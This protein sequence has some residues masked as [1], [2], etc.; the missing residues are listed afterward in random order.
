MTERRIA[1][2]DLGKSTAKLVLANATSSG[3]LRI[4]SMESVHHNG[5]AL[6]AFRAWYDR[7]G[8]ATCRALG[9]TG[10]HADEIAEPALTALP[11]DVC[12]EAALRVRTD[13]QGP[14]NLVSVGARGYSVLTRDERGRVQHIENDKCSSGTGETIVKTASR[15]DMDLET[16]DRVAFEAEKI[17]PI[18]ARCSVF[19]KSEMTHFGNQGRPVA[20]LFRGYFDSIA[21]YVAAL[22]SRVRV[23]GPIYLIGGGSRLQTLRQRLAEHVDARVEVPDH[24][25]LFEAMGAACLAAEGGCRGTGTRLPARVEELIV[26]KERSFEVLTPA[27][28]WKDR[29][30]VMDSPVVPEGAESTSAV[31]GIDLGSTGSKAV[32]TSV[33]TGDVVLDLYD[34]TGG[35]PVEATQRLVRAILER[36]GEHGVD[37]RAI[38]L[39]GSGREAAATVLRAALPEAVDRILVINEIVAH[40]TAAI[41]CDPDKGKSLSVVEIGGQDAKFIQIAD[42]RIVES[43]MNK[44]CSAGTGSFLEEQAVFYGVHDI[45]EFT[46][47]ARR[48]TRPPDLGQMCTVFVAEAAAEAQSAGF[49]V[50]DLFAGFQYSVIHNYLHR[51]MG[52]RTFGKRVFFQGKPASGASL[53][54]TLAAVADRDIIVPPNPGAMGA[55]GIGLCAVEEMGREELEE[56]API[57]LDKVLD[58]RVTGR[59]E[60]QCNDKRCATLCTIERTA[61]AVAENESVVY[62]GGACPKYEISTAT[63]PKLDCD[64][65][66]AFDERQELL[67][68]F[69]EPLPVEAADAAAQDAD[70][71]PET[72]VAQRTVGIPLASTLVGF[73][74]WAVTLLRELG[75]PVKVLRPDKGTLSRGEG[76]CY[77]YDACAPVKIAHGVSDGEVDVLFAPKLLDLPDRDGDGGRTCA[78][79]QAMPDMVGHALEARGR[80]VDVVAP[81][82]TLAHGL[83]SAHILMTIG[84]VAKRIGAD[85]AR[86]MD[87]MNRAAAAQ[88]LYEKRLKEIGERTLQYGRSKGLA[89]VVVCG[90]LHVIMEPA[91]NAGIPGILRQNGVLALPQDCYPI[92]KE[93]DALPRAAWLDTKRGLRV[94]LAARERGDVFPLLLSAFACSPASFSEQIFT[95]LM[96]GYP[97]TALETDGHGGTAGYV[98]RIQSFLHG[99]RSYRGGASP[100]SAERLKLI[101]PPENTPIRSDK[102]AQLVMFAA[103]DG[104]GPLAAATYRSMGFDA[105]TA[106]QASP[107]TYALG[108]KDCSGKECLPYQLLWG[109]FRHYLETKPSKKRRVLLQISGQGACRN[110]M[111]SI[112]DKMSLEHLGMGDKV[113]LR[114]FSE[115][116]DVEIDA[117]TR[118]LAGVIV[119]DIVNQLAAYHRPFETRAGEVDELRFLM[120]KKLE[121]QV[122]KVPPDGLRRWIE[123][124][125]GLK[126]LGGLVDEAAEAFAKFDGDANGCRTVMLSGD[127]YVRIDEYG[128][129]QLVRRLNERGL[130]VVLDPLSTSLEYFAGPGAEDLVGGA[131]SVIISSTMTLVLNK[132]RSAL[133]ARA[134]RVHPWLPVPSTSK[135]LQQAEPVLG[136]HPLGEAPLTI[137]SVL[138]AWKERSCDGAVVVGPWGCSPSL[139]TESLLRHQREIPLLFLYL[140]GAP[141]NERKLNGFAHR[142]KT[143]ERRTAS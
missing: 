91:L 94:A 117:V 36:T 139:I 103:S 129:E 31:L 12:L 44:A 114:H 41:R 9:A 19:A 125:N 11:E 5:N 28:E 60:I 99:V 119:W 48:A 126:V 33:A 82:L 118:F 32:L 15:F 20:E 1:G 58:A 45:C 57:E 133:Y 14:I 73:L 79:E 35:N 54:W 25:L 111:F 112:K 134:R 49:E 38:G 10:V 67:R 121:A 2:V 92:P 100:V 130:R 62:S 40:A 61:V 115:E 23:G 105:V 51:V 101:A 87:A 78:M 109:S 4:E 6:S 63:R 116:P 55:W 131:S 93:I 56:D 53:A 24:A 30:T 17:I 108:R 132:V 64:A 141:L 76:R 127:I 52:Q 80:H 7:K 39:T 3:A 84:S 21:R 71:G 128:N 89:V 50:A 98:T 143:S 124:G 65:P 66:S 95:T 137:G 26:P 106:T 96:H 34:R 104:I 18:T 81:V 85:P 42:G 135:P 16:A 123:V 102:D 68:E 142:L 59:S 122:E 110:C 13:L 70:G 22:L 43:D 8:A 90:S 120:N 88:Q 75:I 47:V 86:I 136:K 46:A 37:V 97:H 107:E 83:R 72:D 77:S 138:Q 113:S 74:P 69:I 140:D 27:A 29:V